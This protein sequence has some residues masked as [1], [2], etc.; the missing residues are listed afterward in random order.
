MRVVSAMALACVVLVLAGCASGNGSGGDTAQTKAPDT[1]RMSGSEFEE[2]RQFTSRFTDESE[3]FLDA[4]AGKCG[5]LARA[6]ELA[7]SSGCF[8]DAYGGVDEKAAG[9]Y[10][11][12]SDLV[13]ATAKRCRRSVR[14]LRSALDHYTTS[15]KVA[16]H[17]GESL[18]PNADLGTLAGKDIAKQRR[19]F[20]SRRRAAFSACSPQ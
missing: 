15:L 7:A 18:E 14:R 20:R 1:G 6:G 16:E 19:K 9:A 12:Y 3:A 2:M 4:V 11:V 8:K 5:N 13:K 10:S 17:L